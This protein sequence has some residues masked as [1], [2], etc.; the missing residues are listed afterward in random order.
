MAKLGVIEAFQPSSRIFRKLKNKIYRMKVGYLPTVNSNT[1]RESAKRYRYCRIIY[2]SIA[3]VF[4]RECS[5][6][7]IQNW[8]TVPKTL[9]LELATGPTHGSWPNKE[10][11]ELFIPYG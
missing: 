5:Q 9:M 10:L 3:A 8:P 1:L 11:L 2:D 4:G 6:I 7:E